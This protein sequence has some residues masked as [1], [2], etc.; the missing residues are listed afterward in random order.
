MKAHHPRP[1]ILRAV[2][3]AQ[4]ARPDAARRAQLRDFLEEVVVNVPEERQ[5]RRELV[6]V[7]PTSETALHVCEAVS[8]GERELLG[9]GRTRLTDVV[10]GDGDRVPLRRVLRSPFEA[11]ND[12]AQRGL[13]R[14]AP[15]V[16]RHVLL[17][18]VVLDRAAE[19]LRRDALP[20][21][22]RDVERPENDR[23]TVDR[24]RRRHAIQRDAVE[25]R[26]HVGETRDGDARLA[27]FPFRPRVVGVVAHERRKVECH[28]QAGLPVLEEEL[29]ACVRVTGA[30]EPGE[31]PHR[32]QPP[33]VSG[34]MDATRERESTRDTEVLG[35]VDFGGVEL[36]VEGL[37]VA[38]RVREGCVAHRALPVA[39]APDRH[40]GR[41][42]IGLAAR[43][44]GAV[45]HV[46]C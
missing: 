22:R 4:V 15:R 13:D 18:D 9:G 1:R 16:L 26:L 32:P 21:R 28:G 3:I 37:D 7:E 6:D 27:N 41:D 38:R 10:A 19:L 8:E 20:L 23:R 43:I 5:S 46:A 39:P 17:E 30:A 42:P 24:H 40:L 34:R 36:R 33:A 12:Q 2:T 31:L 45:S 11:V 35:G 29:E 44:L 25:Q 14:E